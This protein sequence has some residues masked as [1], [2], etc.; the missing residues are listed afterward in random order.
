MSDHFITLSKATEMTSKYRGNKENILDSGYKDT[1]ILPVCE[2]FDRAA[3]DT[4]LAQDGCESVRAYFGMDADLKVSL[5]FVGVN[6]S[7]EDLVVSFESD[8][9]PNI[10][11][12]DGQRCPTVCP[13]SSPLNTD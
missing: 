9:D 10:I 5:V 12:E 6:A 11:V 2:T 4:L 8:I 3:F 1:G 13:E 7:G